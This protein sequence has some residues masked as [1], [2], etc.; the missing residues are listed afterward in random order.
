MAGLLDLIKL[1]GPGWAFHAP[2][3]HWGE[4]LQLMGAVADAFQEMAEDAHLAALPGQVELDGVPNLGGFYA[5]DALEYIGRDLGIPRGLA[6]S[7]GAYALRLRRAVDTWQLGGTAWGLLDSVTGILDAPGQT[8]PL[9]RLVTSGGNWYTRQVDGTRRLQTVAGDGFAIAPS[10]TITADATAAHPWDWDGST[11]PPTP[12]HGDG[13]R[14]W[15]IIEWPAAGPYLAATDHTFADP[16]VVGDGWNDPPHGGYEGSPDAGTIGTNA[17]VQ[18]VELVRS[19]VE[20]Q[21]ASGYLVA[22]IIIVPA[23]AAAFKPDGTSVG[24]D[25]YPDGHWGYCSEYD[26]ASQSRIPSRFATAEYW[27]GAPGG[28]AP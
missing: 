27:P 8:P 17:P 20:T 26:T 4:Y 6:E 28:R 3:T 10:G 13:T 12:D 9:L 7:T 24:P 2:R 15:L 23:S 18:L 14:S 25:A 1:V 5:V 11:V 19:V 21:R 22:Y 16:G